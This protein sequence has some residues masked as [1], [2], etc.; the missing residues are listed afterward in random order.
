MAAGQAAAQLGWPG[1]A[2]SPA[3][4]MTGSS[5]ARVGVWRSK[6]AQAVLGS[7]GIGS[8]LAVVLDVVEQWLGRP[9]GRPG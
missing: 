1:S 5:S 9:R 8:D 2:W 4:S 6:P 3:V 7:G